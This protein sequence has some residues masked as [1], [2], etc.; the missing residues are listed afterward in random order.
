MPTITQT[1]SVM[2]PKTAEVKPEPLLDD[3]GAELK[4]VV[5]QRQNAFYVPA[6]SFQS[7]SE[8][9]PKSDVTNVVAP[10]LDLSDKSAGNPLFS[11]MD[12]RIVD[13][14]FGAPLWANIQADEVTEALKQLD[15]VIGKGEFNINAPIVGKGYAPRFNGYPPLAAAAREGNAEVVG[16]LLGVKGIDLGARDIRLQDPIPYRTVLMHAV[17]GSLENGRTVALKL[18]LRDE[19]MDKQ[20][21][22]T[23][24]KKGTQHEYTALDLALDGLRSD[25]ELEPNLTVARLLASKGAK[26]CRYQSFLDENPSLL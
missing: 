1:P 26:A 19:R 4:P 20:L 25:K 21:N 3:K 6:D 5:L 8:L 16:I 17:R 23:S 14:L 2:Q 12:P 15:G 11:A 9:K 22:L 7:A 18:L 24:K 10:K 13:S